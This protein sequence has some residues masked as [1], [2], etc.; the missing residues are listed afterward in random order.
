MAGKSE[1]K[2]LAENRKA[3]HDYFI[4]ESMEAGIELV[5]TEVK[6]IRG[7]KANLKDSYAEIKNG[8]I[9][10]CNMHISPYEKGN[11]FNKDP[12]RERKLLLH[13]S[14]IARLLG[15]TA[16]KGYTLIPLS[17]YLKNGRVKVNLGVA[18]GKK[19]YDKRDAMLEKEAKR[20][21]DRQIKERSKY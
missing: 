20:D 21:I 3:W 14:E 9:F 16:Q 11:I 5:G 18:K 8:E 17:L 6:S 4:E 19:D 10:I 2:T 1:N 7:G 12:L 15:F 13:K